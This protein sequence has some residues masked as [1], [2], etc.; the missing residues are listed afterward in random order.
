VEL[1]KIQGE[2]VDKV[3]A[4]YNG[5]KETPQVFRLFGY[6]GT[7]KTTLAKYI[8]EALDT[9][10]LFATFTGKA[11]SVLEKKGN[12]ASTIHSLIYRLARGDE[13]LIK[14]LQER[15]AN[16]TSEALRG[17]LKRDLASAT[18]PR[19]TLRSKE[20]V[21]AN[22]IVIDEVSMVGEQIGQDLLS[23]G[24]KIL[25]LGDPGQ[26]PPIEGGGYFTA[27]QPDILLTEIHRQARDNPIISMATIVRQGHRLRPGMYGTSKVIHRNQAVDP[28]D[29]SQLICGT[30]RTRRAWNARYRELT[31]RHAACPEPGEK[32]ICLRN[33]RDKGILNGTQW[34]VWKSEDTGHSFNLTLLDWDFDVEGEETT[35]IPLLDPLDAHPFSR[36]LSDEPYYVRTQAEEFDFG[37]CVT[38]HKSQGSQWDNVYIQDESWIFKENQTKW[39]YTA[40]TRAAEKVLVAL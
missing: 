17:I 18:K 13:E 12:S 29:W 8:A 3:I 37:Y 23:F 5:G 32:V 30:N 28:R 40:L 22:L 24:K 16:E 26:L 15:L 14:T 11:A 31:G 6:A 9:S 33:N 39:L 2:A 27:Q 19:F 4:W 20:E 34:R 10:V 25:V 36:D 38:C 1:S 35:A 7:G 21:F